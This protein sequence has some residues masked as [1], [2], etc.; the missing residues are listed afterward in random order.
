M[1]K[2]LSNLTMQQ[3]IDMLCGNVAVLLGK[4]EIVSPAKLDKVRK[5]L[6]FE[7]ARLSD[8]AAIAAFLTERASCIRT[9][10]EVTMFKCLSNALALGAYEQV[11][12]VLR[13]YGLSRPMTDEQVVEEVSRLLNRAKSEI[14]R[15]SQNKNEAEAP[16][17]DQIRTQFDR[18]AAALMTYFKFQ[19]D[20]DTIKASQFACMVSQAD[21][22]IKA[23]LATTG[24]K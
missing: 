20:L 16:T 13:E 7:Y 12:R 15:Q 4:G 6:I 14:K 18:Q 23:L 11:R 1:I 22:Q 19:I 10:V 8:N 2:S 24:R 9:E 17:S 21:K 5:K 3:Y